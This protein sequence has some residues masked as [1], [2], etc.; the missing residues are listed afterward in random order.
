MGAVAAAAG[1][2]AGGAH[3]RDPRRRVE[4]RPATPAHRPRGLRRRH[5]PDGRGQTSAAGAAAGRAAV[6]P[7]PSRLLHRAAAGRRAALR[8]PAAGRWLGG[9]MKVNV[10]IITDLSFGFLTHKLIPPPPAPPIPATMSIEMPTTFLW[11]M[12][13][14][15]N[16]NKFSNGA[17]PVTHK[18]VW[19]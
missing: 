6:L 12:G 7:G 4:L 1:G 3:R 10:N 19:I 11:T 9:A 5:H 18:G 15:M 8:P 17:K 2:S 16:Q 13:F 14:L